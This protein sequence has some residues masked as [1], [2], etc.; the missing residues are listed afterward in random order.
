M[1]ITKRSEATGLI[2]TRGIDISEW[3]YARYQRGELGYVQE[4]FPLL[5]AD[6]RE[7]LVTGVTP[8]E[9]DDLFGDIEEDELADYT[10]YPREGE[11]GWEYNPEEW[12]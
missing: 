8:E 10:D 4:A 2:H 7:F 5:S 9:W 3:E 11:S 12:A 1:E 6:D